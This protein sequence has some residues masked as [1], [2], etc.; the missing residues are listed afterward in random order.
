MA[1]GSKKRKEAEMEH[2]A[3]E[4]MD[5]GDEIDPIEADEGGEEEEEETEVQNHTKRQVLLEQVTILYAGKGKNPG[6]SKG[7]QCKHC[8]RSSAAARQE[9]KCIFSVLDLV[10]RHR[11]VVVRHYKV[12][13]PS[14][15]NCMRR[16]VSL[17][18]N[19]VIQY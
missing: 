19:S 8:K 10:R 3:P 9:F 13:A 11:L 14:I 15:K 17:S 4:H 5:S 1:F 18:L 6:G 12:I 16:C 7:W 2:E